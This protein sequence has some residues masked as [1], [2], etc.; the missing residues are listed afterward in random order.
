MS[1]AS[2]SVGNALTAGPKLGS[3]RQRS[4]LDWRVP[5][6]AMNS[7]IIW[8][9]SGRCGTL[10]NRP[11]RMSLFSELDAAGTTVS[12]SIWF[13]YRMRW[14]RRRLIRR[15][16]ARRHELSRVSV[17]EARIEAARFPRYVTLRNEYARLPNFLA[18]YR[19]LGVDHFLIVDNGSDDGSAEYLEKQPDVSLWSTLAS[20][21]NARFGMDWNTC[22]QFRFGSGKWVLTVDADELLILP[23]GRKLPELVQHLDATGR[24][25]FGALMLDLYPEG[26]VGTGSFDAGDDPLAVLQWFDAP[27]YRARRH[28]VFDNLWIQGGPRARIFF[29]DEP[30]RAPAL[31]K[32]PLVKWDR[33]YAF[34]SSTHM[35]LPRGLN[36]VYDEWGG[37]KASG[38]LLHTKFLDTFTS[39]AREELERKQHY[40]DGQEYKSYVAELENQPELWCKWS[41]KYFN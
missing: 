6:F 20:Y 39:K 2:G 41:E 40:A 30:N 1:L 27:A 24:D 7:P 32:T 4:H 3:F 5:I 15:A 25:S 34:V 14:K 9:N 28:P 31:N 23:H 17:D 22:L 12:D 16:L 8:M 38:I 13:R 35:L 10:P 37:E 21:K 19:A 33:R 36:L 18:H 29:K 11:T 26:P